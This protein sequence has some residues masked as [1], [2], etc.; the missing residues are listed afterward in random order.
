[1]CRWLW[2]LLSPSLKGLAEIVIHE[3]PTARCSYRGN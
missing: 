2:E 1:M 3:T